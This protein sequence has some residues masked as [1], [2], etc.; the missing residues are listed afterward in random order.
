MTSAAVAKTD[1]ARPSRRRGRRR[2]DRITGT[3]H[4]EASNGN[5]VPGPT[6]SAWRSPSRRRDPLESS[7]RVRG[8]PCRCCQESSDSPLTEQVERSA[9]AVSRA[10]RPDSLRS[11]QIEE[12]VIP[13]RRSARAV[14]RALWPTRNL[15]DRH[16]GRARHRQ[17]RHRRHRPTFLGH[18]TQH[19]VLMEVRNPTQRGHRIDDQPMADPM[20]HAK[21]T[22]LPLW[23]P[24]LPALW[25]RHRLCGSRR[26]LRGPDTDGR[27]LVR[28]RVV[29][30]VTYHD[31]LDVRR[32]GREARRS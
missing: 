5:R 10:G 20:P 16:A 11:T 31:G 19:C 23:T 18:R 30:S 32:R 26:R 7:D 21:T 25:V 15:Q 4:D 6:C 8:R 14:D 29:G 28:R 9:S 17:R 12:L 27:I 3:Y 13:S 1:D 2:R 24:S 22:V